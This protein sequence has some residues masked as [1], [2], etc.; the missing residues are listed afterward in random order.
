MHTGLYFAQS[1]L[2]NAVPNPWT[3]LPQV[4]PVI[5]TQEVVKKHFWFP[6]VVPHL[7]RIE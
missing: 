6:E 3:I 2:V 1:E 5:A 7:A 4:D